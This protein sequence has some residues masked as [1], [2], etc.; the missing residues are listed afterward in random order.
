MLIQQFIPK[1][2]KKLTLELVEWLNKPGSG[3]LEARTEAMAH[4]L[5]TIVGLRAV[6]HGDLLD[7][8]D[9]L[10]HEIRCMA[11]DI[12]VQANSRRNNR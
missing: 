3:E 1:T 8:L 10:T 2:H 4:V 7:G 9:A 12:F 11:A 5:A 6:D